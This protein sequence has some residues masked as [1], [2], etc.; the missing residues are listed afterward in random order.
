MSIHSRLR[1]L[2]RVVPALVLVSAPTLRA[3]ESLKDIA[4]RS[5]H[6]VYPAPECLAFY[7]E[8]T[9]KQSAPGTYFM[10]CGW[11]DGYFGIQ[12]AADGRK[13]LIFSVWDSFKG[14]DPG[15]VPDGQRVLLLHQDPQVRV[16]RFGGEGTGGQSFLRYP[17]KLGATYRFMVSA[18]PAGR[19]TEFTGWFFMPKT[20]A[21][22]KLVTF[23]TI[24][25]GRALSD[26]YS[27]IEDFKRDRL[28]THQVRQAA[29]GPGWTLAKDGPWSLVRSATFSADRNPVL[30]INASQRGDRFFLS[31]GGATENSGAHLGETMSLPADSL[32]NRPEDLPSL[33]D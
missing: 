5:V 11:K 28:S 33:Q 14:D 31:T 17:W 32:G 13:Q 7:N 9:V 15:A 19:R 26:C 12:Q 16:G 24:T 23:S 1:C 4:C 27:F 21:W 18:K 25:E 30:T 6:L 2:T 8:V 10:V 3:D 20:Q 22:R 29:Y